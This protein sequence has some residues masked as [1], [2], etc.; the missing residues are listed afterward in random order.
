MRRHGSVPSAHAH[1][2]RLARSRAVALVARA[3]VATVASTPWRNELMA[4]S[5]LA[6][7]SPSSDP[8]SVGLPYMGEVVIG[9]CGE[10]LTEVPTESVHMIASDI[11]Y[12]IGADDW[13]VLHANTDR[14]S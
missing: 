5:I 14:K 8:A 11:P 2:L 3:A 12:G 9:D 4:H 10:L 7:A 1:I 13:D 6:D